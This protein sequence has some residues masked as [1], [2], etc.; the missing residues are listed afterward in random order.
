MKNNKKTYNSLKEI[1]N[2]LKVLNLQ[3][4]IAFEE[5]KLMKNNIQKSLEPYSYFNSVLKFVSKYGAIAIIR[6]IIK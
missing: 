4:E 1:S 2:D 5:L 3:R 6:K